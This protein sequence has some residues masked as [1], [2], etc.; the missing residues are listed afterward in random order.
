VWTRYGDRID[1]AALARLHLALMLTLKGTPFLYYG[2]EIG[3]TD[4][5][6]ASL[7]EIR[8]TTATN[9]YKR[10]TQKLGSTVAEA[11]EAALLFTRDRCRT[12]M[13]WNGSANAGFSPADVKTWLPVNP[14]YAAGVNVAAQTDD[15]G[16]LL[17]FYK[18]LIHLR[19]GTPALI[20][21]GYRVIDPASATCL[22]FLRHDAASNQTCLVALNFSGEAQ[23]LTGTWGDQQA[24]PLFF[25]QGRSGETVPVKQIELLPFEILIAELI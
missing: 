21:G 10:M 20:A 16:S 24:R 23:A 1:D 7:S 13:Q 15:P 17:S 25:G 8:D 9:L 11:L 6:L 12:P 22:I 19:Q 14:N 4:L 3:M 18:Q 2:E 5:K